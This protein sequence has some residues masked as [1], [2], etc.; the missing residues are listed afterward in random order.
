MRQ[1]LSLFLLLLMPLA[2]RA[3]GMVI[4]TVAFPAKITIPDQRALIC[5]SNRTERLVIETR[6]TGSGTNFAWVVPLPNQPVI[7]EATTGLFPTLQ[8][9]F[10]PQ[11]IHNVPGYYLRIFALIWLGYLLLFVRPTGRIHRLDVT[12]CVLLSATITV[13]FALG[14]DIEVFDSWDFI[15]GSLFIFFDLMCIVVLVRFR[16]NFGVLS[17]SVLIFFLAIQLLAILLPSLAAAKRQAMESVP[18]TQAV[19]ILDR[20]IVGVFETTTIASHESKALQTWLSENGYAVPTNSEPVIANYVK[21]GWIFVATKIQHDHGAAVTSTPHP[22]SFTFKTD[23]PVYPMQLTGLGNQSLSVDLYVFSAGRAAAPHFKVESCTRPNIVHPLL[24]Q[25]TAGLSVATKLTA[26]LSPAEMRDDVW[27]EQ[28][29]FTF[30]QKDRLFSRQGALI[31]ALNWGT[32]LFATGLLVVCFLAFASE[33]H[34][35]QLPRSVGIVTA[36][37]IILV[38]VSYLSLPKIEVK[39]VKVPGFDSHNQQLILRM[40]LEENNWST[41]AEARA[42]L[43]EIVSNPTNAASYDLNNW[44]NYFVGGQIREEDSPGNYLLRETNNQLQL[45]TF[46]ADGREEVSDTRNLPP[47][48]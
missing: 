48:H 20:K 9:L 46:D 13:R 26:N 35:K 42:G 32:G 17:K 40:A 18:S 1:I 30:E 7:E 25:W 3:D 36:A 29:P 33:K 27:L 10:R 24:R 38:G 14:S 12:A 45:V 39:L 23:K 43:R 47:Q 11:I 44:D 8:Y 37:S 31:T 4:P 16:E 5:Y 19:S 6:F 41:T 34:K 21:N 2:A 15:I 28:T 22:L